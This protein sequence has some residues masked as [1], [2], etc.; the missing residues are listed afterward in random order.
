MDLGYLCLHSKSA[1]LHHFGLVPLASADPP[2]RL[3]NC[4]LPEH[5]LSTFLPTPRN[6]SFADTKKVLNRE[7]FSLAVEIK[8]CTSQ[9]VKVSFESLF[10]MVTGIIIVSPKMYHR[11]LYCDRNR[12]NI[13]KN[14][15]R[16]SQ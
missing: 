1:E 14:I 15:L 4:M 8:K 10:I 6:Q 7:M 5:L 16:R 12:L 3:L 9:K 2:L 11:R 13:L